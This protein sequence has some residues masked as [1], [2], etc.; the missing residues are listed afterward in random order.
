M[1]LKLFTDPLYF[2]L[3]TLTKCHIIFQRVSF[4]Y[5]FS[6][7]RVWRETAGVKAWTMY[8]DAAF[9]PTFSGTLQKHQKAAFVL[10]SQLECSS[11]VD[12]SETTQAVQ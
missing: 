6:V 10:Y 1:N 7:Y 3:D 9:I 5:F 2:R 12:Y 11:V 4:I 8:K